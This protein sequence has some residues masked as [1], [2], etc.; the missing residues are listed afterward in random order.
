[1]DEEIN[2]LL[3]TRFHNSQAMW[4][5][6]LMNMPVGVMIMKTETHKI[7]FEN[8]QFKSLVGD[9]G[10]QGKHE[11]QIKSYAQGAEL[12]IAKEEKK[13]EKLMAVIKNLIESCK[14]SKSSSLSLESQS[15]KEVLKSEKMLSFKIVH[16]KKKIGLHS[17]L[18]G[19]IGEF[20]IITMNDLTVI[21]KYEKE[22]LSVRF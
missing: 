9:N 16:S 7:V 2:K 21:K 11:C 15:I 14:K 4:F 8:S 22:R 1:M 10:G 6:S 5:K 18:F 20:A 13:T 3:N 19:E 12:K 17:Q